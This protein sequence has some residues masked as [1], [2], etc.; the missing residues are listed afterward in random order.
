MLDHAPKT[1][2]S[3]AGTPASRRRVGASDQAAMS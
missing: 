1:L 2:W 3:A